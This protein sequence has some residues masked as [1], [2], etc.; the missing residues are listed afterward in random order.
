MPEANGRIKK[1]VDAYSLADEL[2]QFAF[3]P[4]SQDE[5]DVLRAFAINPV[6]EELFRDELLFLNLFLV[7]ENLQSL[8]ANYSGFNLVSMHY[9]NGIESYCTLKGL[10][11]STIC[12]RFEVYTIAWN[13]NLDS[14]PEK[15][16][17][18]SPYWELGKAFSR[19]V[20]DGNAD[21]RELSIFGHTFSKKQ[22]NLAIFLAGL[23]ISTSTQ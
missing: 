6:S 23:E 18:L 22:L 1:S 8:S 16:E 4:A 20:A 10:D 13:A 14:D 12:E 3:I 17:R 19:F 9:N 11:Y 21:A 2:L 15:R 7:D 5:L